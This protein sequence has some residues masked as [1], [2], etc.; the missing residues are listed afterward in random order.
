[1][2]LLVAD[3]EDLR[4]ATDVPA[5]GLVIESHVEQGRGPIAHALVEEGI[6]KL[7]DFIVVGSTYAH[8]RNLE[9]SDAKPIADAAPSTPVIITGFKA[10]PEFGD[11]FIV[12]PNER[13]AR[14]KAES[15]AASKR[16]SSDRL[17]M[18]SNE[19]IRMINR[20]NKLR[21]LNVILKAD[22]QGSLTSVASSLKALDTDE[23]AVRIVASGV[24]AVSKIDL[25][26]A[27]TSEAIYMALMF[28]FLQMLSG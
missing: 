15:N 25:Q 1:M 26:L 12:V 22:V 19:L 24:G 13:A 17:G 6:L 2:I 10:L 23:V 9:S 11:E 8:I 21:E 3:V 18:N 4:A 27:R 14:Q 5:S 20:S 28:Y 16:G 7:G